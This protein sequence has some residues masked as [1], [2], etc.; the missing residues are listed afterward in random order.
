MEEMIKDAKP[1]LVHIHEVFPF[2]SPWILRTA[3]HLGIPVVM[4]C[5]NFRL[6]CPTAHL[7]SRT[8]F[9]EL[10][11]GEREYW[12]TLRNCRKDIFESLAFTIRSIVARKFG[13]FKRTITTYIALSEFAKRKLTQ[14]GYA[15]DKIR[16][17]PNM[18]PVPSAPA[19]VKSGTYFAFVG[20][21]SAEKGIDTLIAAARLI[22]SPIRV[23]GDCSGTRDA[24][25]NC[26][27]NV[28]YVGFVKGQELE[29]LYQ[30]ARCLMLPSKCIEVNPLVV[31]E[32]MSYGLPVIA[33]EVGGIPEM[34]KDGE[35]GF[36]FR[37]GDHIQLAEK[38]KLVW[39][40]PQLARQLGQAGRDKATREYSEA[41][42]FERLMA[43]YGEAVQRGRK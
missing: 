22:D 3:S 11:T 14:A 19:E 33:S 35:T 36:L 20:R 18:V 4:S 13:L 39:Q 24:L 37:A 7:I 6:I 15:E 34:V 23:A 43:I 28:H 25:Q 29:H 2:I 27:G 5:H 26:P 38:M 31:A 41:G 42:Y 9:C 30:N 40:N 17:L 8:G 16:V 10:C 21:V 32:A 12:C 1:D